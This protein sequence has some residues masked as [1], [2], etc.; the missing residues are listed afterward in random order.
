[1]TEKEI[2]NGMDLLGITPERPS[3]TTPAK[4]SDVFTMYKNFSSYDPSPTIYSNNTSPR[5]PGNYGTKK[6]L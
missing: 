6:V 2:R 1:M 3:T 4:C 5:Y